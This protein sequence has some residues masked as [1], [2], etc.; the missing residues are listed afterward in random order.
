MDEAWVVKTIRATPQMQVEETRAL[1]ERIIAEKR[2]YIV[3]KWPNGCR[4]AATAALE[5][6]KR[7]PL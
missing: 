1:L 7:R 6:L 4:Q 3:P 2:M 5:Q